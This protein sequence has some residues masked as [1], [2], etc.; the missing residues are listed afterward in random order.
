MKKEK[1]LTDKD[2]LH[3]EY[4]DQYV[5][6]AMDADTKLV[7]TFTVGKRN[8]HTTLIFIQ[9]L[10]DKLQNN[11]RIQLTSD[12]FTAFP[13]AIE[14]TFGDDINYAQIIKTFSYTTGGYS[15]PEMVEAIFH[16]VNGIPDRDK[17]STSFIERQNLTLRMQ[18]RRFTRLTNAF[19]KKL[20]NLK[21]A[22]SLHFAHYNFMR[23]HKT[24]RVTPAMEA[25]ITDHV[26]GWKELIFT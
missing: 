26:W 7:P 14:Q 25:K 10:Y 12:G 1:R 16:I 9:A 3:G 5:F 22:I 19:S 24:L 4:G 6:V 17:A 20:E 8:S 18:M 11:G 2:R 21:A 15:P 13:P 23:I